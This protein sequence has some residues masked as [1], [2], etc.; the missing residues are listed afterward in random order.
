MSADPVRVLVIGDGV[1]G[2]AAAW[3]AARSG[4]HVTLVSA[5]AGA[6]AL[7]GG[8]VDDLP[9]EDVLRAARALGTEPRARPIDPEL[10]AFAGALDLW[11]LPAEGGPLALLA[12]LAGRTRLARGHDRA[13]LDLASVGAGAVAVPRVDRAGWDADSL[14]A[15]WS[16]DP[17][18]RDRSLSFVPIDAALLRFGG[19]DRLSDLDLASR[20]DDPARLAWLADRLREA[21]ARTAL[22]P[23]AV[24]LGPWLGFESP[25]A[26]ALGSA[27]GI[28]TGEAL[29]GVGG[30][31]GMRLVHARDR[32]LARA[33]VRTIA[34]RVTDVR[35]DDDDEGRPSVAIEGE[36]GRRAVDRVVLACGGLT[37]G[38]ILYD[39]LDRHAGSDM[40]EEY[41]PPF[42][43][44]FTVSAADEDE[45]P[46]FAAGGARLGVTGSMFGPALDQSAW[47]SPGRPGLLESIGVACDAQGLCGPRL[48]AAGDV[49]ADRPRTVLAAVQS[50]LRA[51]A[52]AAR[53]EPEPV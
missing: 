21:V 47:P 31:A 29:T 26:A 22:H 42:R 24:L 32:L 41:G 11:S 23:V 43:L 8:A 38:G 2:T 53:V 37:G 3:R 34:A 36:E 15:C 44:S 13:L 12:T 27:L 4:A 7:S 46:Y 33:G 6:S 19:E 48:A 25:R 52:W 5:G 10:A 20:H 40:P 30:P 16:T 14:A 1:A 39:P 18:A 9:W 17:S 49:V 51:G 50:G 45:L 28:R 35:L